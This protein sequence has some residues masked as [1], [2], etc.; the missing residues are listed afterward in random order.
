VATYQAAM[1]VY[2]EE[3]SNL[4]NTI[5]RYKLNQKADKAQEEVLKIANDS[6][7]QEIVLLHEQYENTQNNLTDL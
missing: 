3:H 4:E 2:A 7:N 6:A 5:E 1:E